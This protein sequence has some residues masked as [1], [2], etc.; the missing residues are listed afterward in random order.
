MVNMPGIITVEA[1]SPTMHIIT[2]LVFLGHEKKKCLN[3]KMEEIELPCC[4]GH[5][6]HGVWLKE[7]FVVF[8]LSGPL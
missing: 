5:G 3:E 4:F 8:S 7:C 2:F 6:Q 1:F